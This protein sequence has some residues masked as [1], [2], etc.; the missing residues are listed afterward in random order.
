LWDGWAS[1]VHSVVVVQ[2]DVIL[3]KRILLGESLP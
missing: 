1:I 3:S 2:F